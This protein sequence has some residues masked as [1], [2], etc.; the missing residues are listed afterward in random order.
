M[1]ACFEPI[2]F[3]RPDGR[4]PDRTVVAIGAKTLEVVE[5][6][7]SRWRPRELDGIISFLVRKHGGNP[8]DRG[9]VAVTSSRRV[10][11]Q[12]EEA[13]KNV[14]DLRANSVFVSEYYAGQ[15]LCVDFK[16][17]LVKPL[18]YTI[19]SQY[20]GFPNGP[21]LRSWVVEASNNG[22]EWDQIDSKEDNAEL[23]GK[24]ITKTWEVAKRE[25]LVSMIRIRQT[26]TSHDGSER[27][28]ISAIEFFGHL[29]Y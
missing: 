10:K 18:H 15:W 2:N 17:M 14:L 21:N 26:G 16:E 9:V 28:V 24:N 13:E 27:F 5:Y 23:N 11:A 1:T 7:S 20:N 22:T 8:H 29:Y 3:F 4:P 19:R 12:P 25:L 6:W